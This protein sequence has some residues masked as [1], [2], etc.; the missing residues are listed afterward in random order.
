MDLI[1]RWNSSPALDRDIYAIKDLFIT[2]RSIFINYYPTVY[3]SPCSTALEKIRRFID[4]NNID[5]ILYKGG[6]IEKDLCSVCSC[7]T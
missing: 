2:A 5:I 3:A 1:K 6:E 7:S 4:E